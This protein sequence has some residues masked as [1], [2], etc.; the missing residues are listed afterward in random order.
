MKPNRRPR[1]KETVNIASDRISTAQDD[2]DKLGGENQEEA[3][4]KAFLSHNEHRF[5]C[6]HMM[7]IPPPMQNQVE[8][9]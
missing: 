8:G 7:H 9:F 2:I 4:G 1:K 6:P 3:A 5:C